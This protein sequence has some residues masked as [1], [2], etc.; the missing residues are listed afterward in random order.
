MFMDFISIQVKTVVLNDNE[1]LA[2]TLHGHSLN[3]PSVCFFLLSKE[4][5]YYLGHCVDTY[6]YQR[7]K[8]FW[9]S[10]PIMPLPY[11]LEL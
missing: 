2:S 9:F 8:A 5:T 3:S 7:G 1:G 4:V 10:V 6:G 11:P